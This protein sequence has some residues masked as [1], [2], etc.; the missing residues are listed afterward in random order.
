VLA[1]RWMVVVSASATIGVGR[2]PLGGGAS[3]HDA[4][5]CDVRRLRAR[6]RADRCGCA[7][8]CARP[9]A[10]AGSIVALSGCRR[11]ARRLRLPDGGRRALD[12][13][14]R[15][16]SYQLRRGA[17]P[18]IWLSDE[19]RGWCSLRGRESSATRSPP[20]FHPALSHLRRLAGAVRAGAARA[21][22]ATCSLPRLERCALVSLRRGI[23]IVAS[24]ALC[25]CRTH[26]VCFR[27]TRTSATDGAR[28]PARWRLVSSTISR[29]DL[30]RFRTRRRYSRG[31]AGTCGSRARAGGA[32]SATSSS[33][34]A[35]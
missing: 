31:G 22:R 1:R 35:L 5:T 32:G 23:P 18:R 8:S 14:P 25:R 16:V 19:R 7:C 30:P 4:L 24:V 13:P 29:A 28:R 12:V 11:C 33:S 34:R 17:R 9:R 15:S 21:S 6:R 26:A 10:R 3:P 20:M 27:R 2:L